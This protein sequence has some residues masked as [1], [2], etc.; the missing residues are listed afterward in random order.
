MQWLL[1]YL[2]GLSQNLASDFPNLER[3][4]FDSQIH[5]LKYIPKLS[6]RKATHKYMAFIENFIG[7]LLE[8]AATDTDRAG[9]DEPAEEAQLWVCMREGGG[10]GEYLCRMFS[11]GEIYT[12]E[13]DTWVV[14]PQMCSSFERHSNLQMVQL[15]KMI[16][17]TNGSCSIY[18]E[19]Q[20]DIS[21]FQYWQM[22][23]SQRMQRAPKENIS[24]YSSL[25]WNVGPFVLVLSKTNT[26]ANRGFEKTL[27][28]YPSFH[29]WSNLFRVVSALDR[30][31]QISCPLMISSM[32]MTI[33]LVPMRN[34]AKC[35]NIAMPIMTLILA[36]ITSIMISSI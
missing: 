25:I 36:T 20:E 4:W 17:I 13:N 19:N 24:R 6:W 7:N 26:M 12:P 2:P 10:R 18:Q 30:F 33:A 11:S 23:S 34:M 35:P 16:T 27:K 3:M 1:Q 8:V 22:S 32:I 9:G 5:N 21:V 14:W 15:A 29:Q 28:K 31:Y